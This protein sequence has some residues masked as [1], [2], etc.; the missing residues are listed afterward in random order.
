VSKLLARNVRASDTVARLGGDEFS[1]ILWNLGEGDA[2]SKAWALEAAITEAA[3]EWEG[4]P[5]AVGASIGFA[6]IGPDDELGAVVARA[7]RAM[8]ARKAQRKGSRLPQS[9]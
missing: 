4:E 6:M 3:V 1:L 8:Y 9:R 2:A 7:D 5:L